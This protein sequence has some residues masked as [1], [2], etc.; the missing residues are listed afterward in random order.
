MPRTPLLDETALARALADLPGWSRADTKLTRTFDC[1]TFAGALRL[2]NAV[3]QAA[4]AADHHPDIDIRY[5]RVTFTLTT[6]DSGGLTQQD[7]D[8][9]LTIDRLAAEA[10]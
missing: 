10:G 1:G 5:R 9:A 7:V 4:E 6:H 2:V 8:L 3:G